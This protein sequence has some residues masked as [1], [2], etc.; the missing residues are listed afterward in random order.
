MKVINRLKDKVKRHKERNTPLGFKLVLSDSINFVNEGD[1]EKVAEQGSVFLSKAYLSTIERFSPANTEQRYAIAYREN[2]PQVIVACQIA[3]ISG[4]NFI[5]PCNDLK[6]KVAANVKE[7]LIVCGNLVSSGLHG[8][9]F[10]ESIDMETA[11]RLVAEITYRIRKAEHLNGAVDF[12]MIKDIKGE[13]LSSS[14]VVERYSYRKIKTDPDMVLNLDESVQSFEDYLG[15]LTSKYRSKVKKIAN[16]VEKAGY[17]CEQVEVGYALDKLLHPLYLNVEN[18]SSTRLATLPEGYFAGLAS[19]LGD[20]FVCYVIH[21]EEKIAGF[22]SIIIDGQKALAYYVGV[23]YEVNKE[24]PI[25]FRLLQLVIECAVERG[26]KTISFGRTALEPKASLGAKPVEAY[27]WARHR[28]PVVNFMLRQL[29]G[30]IPY[31]EAPE[32]NVVKT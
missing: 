25:Y 30:H 9:A 29:F 18:K 19:A 3:E 14:S 1:W 21:N 16:T 20:K 26:I 4:L 23:D 5:H 28:V 31:E 10:D 32:R 27:V 17:K 12:A 7:R 13:Q 6:E 22:I 2:Q 11:W 24:I 15:I 8:V